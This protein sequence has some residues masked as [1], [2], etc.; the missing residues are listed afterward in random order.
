MNKSEKILLFIRLLVSHRDGLKANEL[1]MV[2][3]LKPA[4]FY[5]YLKSLRKTGF[6]IKCRKDGKY[7]IILD[8]KAERMLIDHFPKLLIKEERE[9]FSLKNGFKV[10]FS[11]MYSIAEKNTGVVRFFADIPSICAHYPDLKPHI[12]YQ[13]WLLDGDMK[14]FKTSKYVI[15]KGPLMQYDDH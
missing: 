13:N 14:S 4:A 6:N 11:K 10:I 5:N 1:M 3:Q 8:Q 2:L 9:N 7:I 12:I 15:N